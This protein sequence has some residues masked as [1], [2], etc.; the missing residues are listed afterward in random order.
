IQEIARRI[1]LNWNYGG[2][3]DVWEEIRQAVPSC[4]GITWERL[5]RE[6]AVTYPCVNE[7]DP[8]QEVIF[9]DRF[10][11]ADG[12]AKLV[13]AEYGDAEG[14]DPP[15]EEYPFA[16]ITGRIL[17]HWHTGSMTRRAGVLDALEP[18]ATVSMHPDDMARMRVRSGD[19]VRLTTKR[20]ELVA[21]A[22]RDDGVPHQAVFMPFAYV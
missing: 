18:V 3:A 13:P 11:T 21:F 6:H 17:E 1:G 8:G 16:L 7:G 14:E 9:T 15:D 19:P 22:R 2:P 5:E 4:R 20:G 10:P 12:R